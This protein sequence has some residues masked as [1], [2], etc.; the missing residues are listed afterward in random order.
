MPVDISTLPDGQFIFSLR[1][2]NQASGVTTAAVTNL[3]NNSA[4]III[5]NAVAQGTLV[6][7]STTFSG[8][9]TNIWT[10]L[11]PPAVYLSTN[12]GTN[13]TLITNATN[14]STNFNTHTRPDGTNLFYFAAVSS[15]NKTN[16]W[17]QTNIIDNSA[18]GLGITSPANGATV[19]GTTSWL[20]TN[21]E[22]C[23]AITLLQY[24][25]NYSGS[26]L[27]AGADHQRHLH[28]QH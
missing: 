12:L 3:I 6:R 13:Y 15:N 14:W 10:N 20:V 1:S 4:P 26:W 28:Q 2:S 5:Q 18:P 16:T 21:T 19:S 23:A 17:I 9:A 27:A 11:N 22:N 25:T 7:S 24:R 8:Y